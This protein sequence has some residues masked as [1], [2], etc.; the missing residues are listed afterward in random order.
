MR[1]MYFFLLIFYIEFETYCN[2]CL[3]VLWR[4]RR[5]GKLVAAKAEKHFPCWTEL[6]T[7]RASKANM[8][9]TPCEVITRL[10]IYHVKA[11]N[12]SLGPF[13]DMA[14]INSTWY[15]CSN[16]IT[17]VAASFILFKLPQI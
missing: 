1:E 8:I 15:D 12:T 7:A 4:R 3:C 5:N 14:S 13:R 9:A 2:I 10:A 17:K 16:H 6:N 11:G